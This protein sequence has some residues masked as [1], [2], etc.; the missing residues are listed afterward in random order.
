M[1]DTWWEAH[2]FEF[3]A[4]GCMIAALVISATIYIIVDLLK[5][6]HDNSGSDHE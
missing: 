5:N 1:F 2:K 3:I 6:R 4:A